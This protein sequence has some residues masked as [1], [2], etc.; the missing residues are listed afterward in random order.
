MFLNSIKFSFLSKEIEVKI[1][2]STPQVWFNERKVISK[3]IRGPRPKE[4][5]LIL[6]KK[7]IHEFYVW[8]LM[9]MFS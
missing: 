9:D 4:K 1:I 7:T 3:P 8:G 5:A 2:A 6:E